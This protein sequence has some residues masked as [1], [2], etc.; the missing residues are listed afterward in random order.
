MSLSELKQN[1]KKKNNISHGNTTQKPIWFIYR[2]IGNSGMLA[3]N[4]D[5]SIFNNTLCFKKGQFL[6]SIKGSPPKDHYFFFFIVGYLFLVFF[7]L[8]N[9]INNNNNNSSLC[10]FSSLVL[11]DM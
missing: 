2:K 5:M 11:V 7:C 3:K 6:L 8:V 4:F 1:K 9:Q 10:Q